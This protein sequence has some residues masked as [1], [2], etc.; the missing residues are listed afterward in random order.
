MYVFI[1][2]GNN[3]DV[4]NTNMVFESLD[5]NYNRA[6]SEHIGPDSDSP[7]PASGSGNNHRTR[8]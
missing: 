2:C 3:G 6:G 7:P 1:G 8:L 4:V 5:V